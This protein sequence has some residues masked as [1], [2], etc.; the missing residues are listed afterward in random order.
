MAQAFTTKSFEEFEIDGKKDTLEWKDQIKQRPEAEL[1]AERDV[2]RLAI[3]LWVEVGAPRDSYE[4]DAFPLP[5]GMGSR[6]TK[7]FQTTAPELP[8]AIDTAGGNGKKRKNPKDCQLSVEALTQ[9]THAHLLSFSML[10]ALTGIV[11][12]FTSYPLWIRVGLSP[13]VLVFQIVDI[14]F[15]W[16]ARLPDVGPYFAVGIMG[17]GAIVGLGL[18]LQIVLSLFNMYGGK[19]KAILLILLLAGVGT[20]GLVYTKYIQPTISEEAKG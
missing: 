18:T 3:K 13:V 17:T 6:I 20:G 1:L 7:R 2:E 16:L 9:S 15:W 11:F 4:K 12:A 8:K 19:G 10:W 5:E 14:A